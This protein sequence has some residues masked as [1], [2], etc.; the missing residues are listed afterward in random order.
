MGE[1]GGRR[2]SKALMF[3][4]R[5]GGTGKDGGGEGKGYPE[6]GEIKAGNKESWGRGEKRG[7]AGGGYHRG[8]G[9][10]WGART[11]NAFGMNKDESRRKRL[12]AEKDAVAGP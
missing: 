10:Y 7:A 5:R 1:E 8:K 3:A 2:A 12:F 6:E 9:G 11:K 4:T